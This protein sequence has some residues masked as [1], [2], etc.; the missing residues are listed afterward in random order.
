MDG[1]L[2]LIVSVTGRD[3]QIRSKDPQT[4]QRRGDPAQ[5]AQEEEQ[6]RGRVA[7]SIAAGFALDGGVNAAGAATCSGRRESCAGGNTAPAPRGERGRP[8]SWSKPCWR[9]PPGLPR[10]RRRGATPLLSASGT[11]PEKEAA[12]A[13]AWPGGKQ[14]PP[15]APSG[16]SRRGAPG[17]PPAAGGAAQ[18]KGALPAGHRASGPV[19]G[20]WTT[21]SARR[22]W[23]THP[24]PRPGFLRWRK[25]AAIAATMSDGWAR[26]DASPW[27]PVACKAVEVPLTP[28]RASARL[29]RTN[30][31][32]AALL[33]GG[34]L[35]AR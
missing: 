19:P 3:R 18:R 12:R 20:R 6:L 11:A 13:E 24:R 28:T 21:P 29:L 33:S 15:P 34:G 32:G 25:G 17:R 31:S 5:R 26:G 7:G 4:E 30:G 2:L 1:V 16:E 23:R 8:S 35:P 14:R 10:L 27:R 22:R 9:S